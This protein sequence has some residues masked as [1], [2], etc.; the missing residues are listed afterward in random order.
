MNAMTQITRNTPSRSTTRQ[1]DD[2]ILEWLARRTGGETC[3]SIAVSE[4]VSRGQVVAATSRVKDADIAECGD[5]VASGYW[6]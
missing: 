5:D 3:Q 1:R 2:Q 4:G 6:S